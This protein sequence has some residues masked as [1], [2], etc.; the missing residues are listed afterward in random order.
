MLAKGAALDK[1]FLQMMITQHRGAIQMAESDLAQGQNA[2]AKNLA[3]KIIDDQR[4]EISTME[5]MLKS[6]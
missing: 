2:Q 3:R 1:M 6:M 4:G 5:G